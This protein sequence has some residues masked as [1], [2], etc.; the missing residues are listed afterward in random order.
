MVL[1]VGQF[2]TSFELTQPMY[3]WDVKSTTLYFTNC[4]IISIS[5]IY[6]AY[7][8]PF[9]ALI[10]P[11]KTQYCM[12]QNFDGGKYRQ[13]RVGKI[14]M[15]KNWHMPMCSFYR[16]LD[17]HAYCMCTALLNIATYLWL[18]SEKIFNTG[19]H[20]HLHMHYNWYKHKSASLFWVAAGYV[21]A[22]RRA[23]D[24]TL[25]HVQWFAYV[26]VWWNIHSF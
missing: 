12:V 8:Q 20:M 10:F 7:L 19:M 24:I 16:H 2:V 25:Q 14:L 22:W 1:T 13:I 21:R 15:S 17:H 9:L 26:L 6:T 4:I 23:C 18:R 11:R 5:V 3:A